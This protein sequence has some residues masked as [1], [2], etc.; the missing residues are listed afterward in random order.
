MVDMP[1]EQPPVVAPPESVIEFGPPPNEPERPAGRRRRSLSAFAG[2]LAADRR[3][4]PLA[5]ALGGIALFASLVSEWQ[6]TVIDTT[7][8]N[9]E[10]GRQPIPT[11]LIDLGGWGAAYLVGVFAL[12]ATAVLVLFGPPAGRR[13]ARLIGLSVGGVL[14][15]TLAALGPSL[16]DVSRTLGYVIRYQVQRDQF[17][18]TDGRGLWC[19]VIGVLAVMVALWL[20]GRHTAATPP[21]AAGTTEDGPPDEASFW[22]RPRA[23][24]EDEEDRPPAAPID[25]TVAPATPFTSRD[26]DR[27]KPTGRD[28]ISG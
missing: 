10:D 12:V 27:D 16:N 19:A 9:G 3:V 7:V 15:A 24:G 20:A 1:P 18:V 6:T 17:E 2:S 4:V 13:Y 25:L 14:L 22:R 11:D 21:T 8:F 26:D 28:G 23:A 5:A